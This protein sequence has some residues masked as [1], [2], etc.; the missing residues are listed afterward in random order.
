MFVGSHDTCNDIRLALENSIYFMYNSR[1]IYNRVHCVLCFNL[2][3]GASR[4]TVFIRKDELERS[5]TDI[6]INKNAD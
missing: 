2:F 4:Y 6:K 3:L 1:R 5:F